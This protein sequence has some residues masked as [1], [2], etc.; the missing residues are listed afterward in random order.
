MPRKKLDDRGTT[1]EVRFT[2]DGEDFTEMVRI[3]GRIQDATGKRVTLEQ[4]KP[5]IFKAG[6]KNFKYI[7]L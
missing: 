6:T 5:L 2:V 4:L 7:E 3:Q 1:K